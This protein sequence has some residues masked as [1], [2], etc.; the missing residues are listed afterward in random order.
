M[1]VIAGVSEDARASERNPRNRI[2][3][4]TD[5]EGV[6]PQRRGATPS[7]SVSF[8]VVYRGR[9]SP[10]ALGSRLHLPPGYYL[11]PLR[12]FSD[13]LSVLAGRAPAQERGGARSDERAGLG[14]R[15][16]GQVRELLR[17]RLKVRE[18][19]LELALHRVHLLAHVQDYLDAR[20]VHAEVAREA[21]D[22]FEPR[23]VFVRV[24]ARVPL[25]PRGLE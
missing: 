7:G 2:T 17:V 16:L 19:W 18:E 20:E 4:R 25:R 8:I 23:E 21:Q 11:H 5:P 15:G 1:K 14:R 12:G 9:R 6:A 24:E 10:L 3:K 13:V 22:D